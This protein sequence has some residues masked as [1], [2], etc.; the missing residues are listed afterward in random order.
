MDKGSG[1][2]VKLE[3]GQ[4]G[5]PDVVEVFA[6]EEAGIKPAKGGEGPS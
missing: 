6:G 3:A 4:L 2:V 5:S 1:G